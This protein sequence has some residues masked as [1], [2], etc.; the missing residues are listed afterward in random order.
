MSLKKKL[1]RI[2]VTTIRRVSRFRFY[3]NKIKLIRSKID[4]L[5]D[6]DLYQPF[7]DVDFRPTVYD[8]PFYKKADNAY[9][10]FFYSVSLNADI[11]FIP[12]TTY[13][14][15]IEPLLNQ[16]QLL[17]SL[18]NKNAYDLHFAS[19]RTPMTYLRKIDNSYYDTNYRHLPVSDEMLLALLGD[20]SSVILK[21]SIESGSGKSIELFTKNFDGFFSGEKILNQKF[22]DAYPDFVLQENVRQ[23]EYFRNF[24]P[25]SNNTVRILTYRSVKD[26]QIYILHR[27]LRVGK[28]GNFLDHDNFG[29]IAIGISA[30]Y[31]LN[32]FG[33]DTAGNKFTS[34]NDVS[35][36]NQTEVPFMSDLER[37]AK[38][39]AKDVFY[40]RLLAF[41]LTVDD[42]GAPLLI[43]INCWRNGVSQYQMNN[44][45]LFQE[46]TKEVLDHCL[47]KE[48]QQT[49]R[50]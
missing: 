10:D 23:H 30:D 25:D 12:L 47:G 43:E 6:N 4:Y 33:F 35:F 27:L 38:S 26:D 31:N 24:N 21:P 1:K 50:I 14:I 40:G 7:P 48:Y 2:I 36:E 45:S 8:Y 22:L 3:S 32:R 18:T 37:I 20:T 46:F 28:K 16:F 42:S 9:L 15:I 5:K 49:Y 44:G 41:D 11:N 39:I 34:F 19:V 13:F 29:G 17:S